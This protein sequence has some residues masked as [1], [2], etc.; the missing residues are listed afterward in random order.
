MEVNTTMS[1]KIRNKT[2]D[3][4]HSKDIYPTPIEGIIGHRR[5]IL[6]PPWIGKSLMIFIMSCRNNWKW[7]INTVI[8]IFRIIIAVVTIMITICFK[9]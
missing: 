2:E 8:K 9:S 6:N 4:Y 3:W 5:T 7:V 1:W